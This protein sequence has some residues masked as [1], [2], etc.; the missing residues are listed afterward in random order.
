MRIVILANVPVWTLPGLEQLRHS[1]H[2][3][4]WLEPLI[5]AFEK[6]APD[7]DLH[8]IT[9]CK[10]TPVAIEH[11]AHGQT[12]HILPRRKM[13]ISMITGYLGE[14]H[15]IRQIIK[16]LKPDLIH[17]WGSEDVYG[18]A[19]AFSGIGRRIFTLQGCLTEYLRLLGGG[20]LFRL[21]T[22]YEKPTAKRYCLGTAETPAARN[23]LLQL[24][25]T[26]DVLL[27][28]YGVNHEFFDTVWNPAPD[29]E[30]LFVGS[31]SKRKGIGD[32][33]EI[34][35]R[36]E[37][38]HIRFRIAG[39]GALRADLESTA[40]SNV[41]WLGKCSRNE[42]TTHL[43]SAWMMLMPTYSDTGPTVIKEA[44]VVGLPIVTTTGAGASCYVK[45]GE[46]GFV[47]APGDFKAIAEGVAKICQSR[48][49][50][51]SMGRAGW[52]ELREQLHPETT[53]INFATVYRT[54][55]NSFQ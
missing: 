42:I 2:Y 34:A 6:A 3:A 46:T 33:I 28:D 51:I 8:W 54:S 1:H 41:E 20:F 18:L 26:M 9:M 11:K 39:E 40:P 31:I 7:L 21:Q 53:A 29:P 43:S 24:N 52:N 22:F 5:P 37:F 35:R 48:A 13:A 14:I 19:G 16:R 27:V 38:S 30:V 50:C 15:K 49:T 23:L 36:P 10:E 4:T 47:T 12:F 45:E 32:F 25:P 17:A 44:R 55:N